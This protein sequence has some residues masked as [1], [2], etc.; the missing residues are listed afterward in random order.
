MIKRNKISPRLVVTADDF[1][2]SPAVDHGILE[3]Y[4]R[5]IVRSTA[6]LVNFPDVAESVV[7]LRR[8]PGL[9]VGI[10]LN[11]TAGP[12]VLPPD[13]VLSLVGPDGDFHKFSTFFTQ[14]ALSRINWEEVKQEWRAQIERGLQLAGP[15]T[16]V[17]SHQHVHMLPAAAQICASLA[18]EFGIGAVRLSDFRVSEMKWDLRASVLALKPFVPRVRRIFQ[19]SGI[20]FNDSVLEIP[21]GNLE[22]GVQRASEVIKR[23]DGEVHELV[24]HPGYVDSLLQSRDTYVAER[25]TELAVLTNPKLIALLETDGVEH[26]TF[27]EL[28]GCMGRGDRAASSSR[29]ADKSLHPAVKPS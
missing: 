8:E 23:L 14:V 11:L 16:F 5:G 9:E 12:S 25:C 6:L 22:R 29:S 7:R 26:T 4:R 24:C 13:H 17:T 2:L 18:H 1:G 3:S 15:F 19:S 27:R 10:H 20:F 28:A 21:A